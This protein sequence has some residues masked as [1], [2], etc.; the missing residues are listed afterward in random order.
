MNIAAWL[1]FSGFV[2]LSGVAV[3]WLVLGATTLLGHLAD[4]T[5]EPKGGEHNAKEIQA[6]KGRQEL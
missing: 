6:Q 1:A 5:P 3:F 2:L 4:D